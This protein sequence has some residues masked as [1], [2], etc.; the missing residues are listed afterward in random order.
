MTQRRVLPSLAILGVL[1]AGC[2]GSS[3]KPQVLPSIS[4]TP[5]ATS[6][7]AAVPS[8]ARVKTPQGAAAFVRFYFDQLNVAFSTSDASIIRAYSQPECGTC[9][10]YEGALD[11][12]H[13]KG[14][15]IEGT[16]FAVTDVAAAPVTGAT[17]SVEVFGKVPAKSQIDRT[18]AVVQRV[19][20]R[21]DFHFSVSLS[22]G[23]TGW[24]VR[25]I[26]VVT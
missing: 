25:D 7:P 11:D 13:S 16:A 4:V 8:A 5:P 15:S 23:S 19:P 18:G 17:V 26:E 6:S 24:L 10:I 2:S 22:A 12:S 20:A 9:K 14:L 1:L 3:D 21:P